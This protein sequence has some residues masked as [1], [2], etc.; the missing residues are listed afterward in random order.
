MRKIINNE[1][2]DTQ[3][4]ERLATKEFKEIG[5]W[6]WEFQALYRNRNGQYYTHE[7]GGCGTRYAVRIGNKLV[8][9]IFDLYPATPKQAELFLSETNP[10]L[11]IKLFF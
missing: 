4:D 9:G 10:E 2:C 11:A 5:S 3:I 6:E 1:F 7:T 8:G